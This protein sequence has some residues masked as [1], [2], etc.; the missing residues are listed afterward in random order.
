MK[1]HVKAAVDRILQL[2]AEYPASVLGEAIDWLSKTDHF[3]ES[4][5]GA[6]RAARTHQR[7][8]RPAKEPDLSKA[9]AELRT[10]DSERYE[11]LSPF[12]RAIRRGEILKTLGSIR[13]WGIV[14]DKSF[15]PAKSRKGSVARFMQ[16]FVD[17]QIAEVRT[18]IQKIS[19]AERKNQDPEDSYSKLAAFLIDGS[20]KAER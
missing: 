13:E 18:L 7:R 14:I 17:L 9:V 6:A 10:T 16:L 3:G 15:E 1:K 12:D 11:L 5:S 2:R 19:E 4:R 20:R 8:A